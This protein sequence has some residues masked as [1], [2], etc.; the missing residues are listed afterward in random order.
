MSNVGSA[1]PGSF[2]SDYFGCSTPRIKPTDL[3]CSFRMKGV[4]QE[5]FLR[6]FLVLRACQFRCLIKANVPLGCD[7]TQIYVLRTIRFRTHLSVRRM[8]CTGWI[9]KG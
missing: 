1:T 7:R 4:F 6:V 3:F 8:D 2:R 9:W 5:I